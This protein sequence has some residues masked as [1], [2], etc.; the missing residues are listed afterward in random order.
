MSP[1]PTVLTL[2]NSWV[3]VSPADGCNKL[4]NVKLAIDDVL[5]T[6]TTLGI[7]DV[8]PYYYFIGFG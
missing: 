1:L 7:P 2:R 3:H 6:R 5:H 4:S 8:H